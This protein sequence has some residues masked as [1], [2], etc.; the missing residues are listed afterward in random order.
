MHQLTYQQSLK[1][2]NKLFIDVRSPGEFQE[3]TIPGAINIPLFNNKERKTIGTIYKQQS[4]TKARLKAVELVAPKLPEMIYQLNNLSQDYDHL[5]IFCARGGLRSKNTAILSEM[6]GITVKQLKGG[7]KFY[8]KYI[9]ENLKKYQ[10][11]SKLIV[12][13]GN[14]GTGK[15]DLL[16][17]LKKLNH[18]I[19]DLEGIANHRGSAFGGIGLGNANNQKLFDSLLYEQLQKNDSGDYIFLEAE[20]KRIGYSVIPNFFYNKMQQ[21]V[22]YLIE[23][24][25]EKRI[26]NIYQEY[27]ADFTNDK[28]KFLL[29]AEESLQAIK[30]YIVKKIGKASHQNLLYLCRQGNLKELIKILLV[31][32]YD[33]LYNHSQKRIDTYQKI[34]ENSNP[35]ETAAKINA[36][37]TST[38]A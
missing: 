19:I 21:G 38:L 20:S 16:Y 18:K 26:D 4:Q 3:A 5:L 33:P 29:R 31:E 15:T 28:E 7:Y 36:D 13:H 24:P 17:E 12:L 14:T 1:L 10:L 32:Y 9:L 30:K 22:H 25:L 11:K 37:L 8:R 35:A 2:D 23:A 27:A 34:Y 6:A